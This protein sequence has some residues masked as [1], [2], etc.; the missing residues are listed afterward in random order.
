LNGAD[1][2]KFVTELFIPPVLHDDQGK[3]AKFEIALR[4]FEQQILPEGYPKTTIW[5]YGDPSNPQSFFPSVW[6]DRSHSQQ[7]DLRNL[8][9]RAG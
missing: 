3:D 9:K 2:P 6:I 7:E 8:E 5:G 1:I 4:Q